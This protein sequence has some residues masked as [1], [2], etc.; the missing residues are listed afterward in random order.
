MTAID[1]SR[2]SEQALLDLSELAYSKATAFF[3]TEAGKAFKAK[4]DAERL[5]R[6]T[7]KQTD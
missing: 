5:A 3:Q 1:T 7:D 4:K 2:I 6:Q